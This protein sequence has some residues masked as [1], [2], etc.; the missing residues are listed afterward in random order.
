MS[1]PPEIIA[2][3]TAAL[4]A[5]VALAQAI[6]GAPVEAEELENTEQPE[7]PKRGRPPA[8]AKGEE[9][10]PKGKT[11]EELQALI[12][13]LVEAGQQAEV[14]KE[15]TKYA[16]NLKDLATKPEKHAAFIRDIEALSL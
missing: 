12:K 11:Y 6:L 10:K 3:A 7:K 9:E 15:I 13:P 4:A 8:A 14:K 5:N 16:E 1:K 2:L